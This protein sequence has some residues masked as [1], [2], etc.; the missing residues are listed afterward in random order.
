[1]LL[2][3]KDGSN[4][5]ATQRAYSLDE[6]KTNSALKVDFQYYLAQQ[7]HPVVSRLCDL[8]EGIDSVRIAEFLGLDP[9]GYRSSN[10]G[11]SNAEEDAVNPPMSDEDRF[12]ACERFQFPCKDCG[13]HNTIDHVFR[14]MVSS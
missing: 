6:M 10:R 13:A 1:M 11:S 7:V 9:S 12:M 14:T 4:L 8:L 2:F 5:G 3:F